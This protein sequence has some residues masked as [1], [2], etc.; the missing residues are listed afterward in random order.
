MHTYS[1][2]IA[3]EKTQFHFTRSLYLFTKLCELIGS[4]H[5][6]S[7]LLDIFNIH[8]VSYEGHGE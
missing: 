1:T 8:R 3:R 7:K 4:A 2:Y 6:L 5:V